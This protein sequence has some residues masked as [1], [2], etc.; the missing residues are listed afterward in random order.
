VDGHVD[1]L[2]AGQRSDLTVFR[3]GVLALLAVD[4]VLSAIG[5]A[6]FLPSYIGAI[7]F[8]IS[9]LISGVLNAALVWLAGRLTPSARVAALPLWTW[10][11]AVL[12][13]CQSGPGGDVI[14]AGRGIMAYGLLLLLA[15]GLVPS[16]WVLLRRR[17]A[18]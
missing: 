14:F 12:F 7:P 17:P 15:A 13:M 18:L 1:R 11:L 16:V 2:A 5:G 4:G 3:I 8:P 9:A 6:L 10:L